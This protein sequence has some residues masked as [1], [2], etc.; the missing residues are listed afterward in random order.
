MKRVNLLDKC[1]PGI[2]WAVHDGGIA[3][4]LEHVGGSLDHNLWSAVSAKTQP[5]K[6]KQVHGHYL[7]SG[8][9][10]LTTASYQ[11]SFE[12][13]EKYQHMSHDE[14][15]QVL[16]KS[17]E[18]CHEARV[19]YLRE[20][21]EVSRPILIAASLSCYGASIGSHEFDGDYIDSVS[22]SFLKEFHRERIKCFLDLFSVESSAR[23]P[24]ILL[25]ETIPVLKEALII[26]DVLQELAAEFDNEIPLPIILSFSCKDG[27]HTCHG[28][29][30]LT[31]A[32]EI[33]KYQFV[34]AIGINCTYPK[35]IAS[36]VSK[37]DPLLVNRD[38]CNLHLLL[39]PNS[40]DIW[41][42]ETKTFVPNID[43]EYSDTDFG[44]RLVQ[45]V[46]QTISKPNSYKIIIGGC[47]RVRPSQISCIAEEISK[48]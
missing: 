21:P 15:K 14:A 35:Y 34:S 25:F 41:D 16:L 43:K 24:D 47:C 36:L 12:A 31:C 3:T 11:F 4:E 7:E 20:H 32:Q 8:C 23:K 5:D 26:C 28:E 29:P 17:V 39:Y 9:N 30:I 2:Q 40:G 38:E 44:Q 46:K 27:E 6:L 37:I 13:F 48:E 33:S 22:E 1:L 45:S 18:L 42:S 10:I 19:E